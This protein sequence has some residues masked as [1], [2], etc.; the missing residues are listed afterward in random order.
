M[1]RAYLVLGPESTG[2]R[3]ATS[4][5]IAGG[6]YGSAEH[7]QDFDTKEFGNLDPVVWR[8]SVPHGGESL[9]IDTLLARCGDRK[10][11]AVVTTRD[12]TCTIR[13]KVAAY[14]KVG[15][16]V[17]SKAANKE[18]KEAYMSIFTDLDKFDIPFVVLSY[19]SLV[20]HTNKVQHSLLTS[21]GLDIPV[22]YVAV[23]DQNKK[24]WYR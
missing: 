3:L 24:H 16:A 4:I 6:C 23:T 7:Q 1:K 14:K 11:F 21:I 13:S 18:L 19:E 5:L 2:T 8:R 17:A 9:R 20:M 22:N 15:V 10:V 12:W